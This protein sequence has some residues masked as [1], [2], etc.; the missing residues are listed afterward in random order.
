MYEKSQKSYT[1]LGTK[2]LPNCS[3]SGLSSS[4]CSYEI[5]RR[6]FC[7]VWSERES[8]KEKGKKLF[9]FFL[10]KFTMQHTPLQLPYLSLKDVKIYLSLTKTNQ[11][12]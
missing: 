5:N 9:F 11:A 12:N 2:I 4:C 10:H 7:I 1:C 3:T 6:F 8:E